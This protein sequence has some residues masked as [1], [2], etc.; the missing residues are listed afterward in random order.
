MTSRL[1]SDAFMPSVPMDTPSLTETVLNSIGCPPA[2]ADALLDVLG[3]AALVVVAWHRLDP[4]RRHSDEWFGEIVIG[5]P[6]RLEHRSGTGS[7]RAVKRAAEWR[8]GV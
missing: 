6:D 3:E 2:A 8:L 7:V 5:E 1:M 4:G